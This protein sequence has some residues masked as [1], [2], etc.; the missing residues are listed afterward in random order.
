MANEVGIGTVGGSISARW[1]P[2]TH[3]P[4]IESID[5][6]RF[7]AVST[8]NPELAEASADAFHTT[9]Y[10]DHRELI[11]DSDVDVVVVVERVP[12]HFQPAMEALAGG[13]HAYTEWPLGANGAVRS[14]DRCRLPEHRPAS[15]A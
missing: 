13:K 8:S 6:F 2:R 3:I 12:L 7:A 15:R 14:R 10:A 11:A 1:A 5:N 9:G 4:V